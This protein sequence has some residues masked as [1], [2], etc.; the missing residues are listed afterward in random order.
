MAR[1]AERHPRDARHVGD[2]ER[3]EDAVEVEL[4]IW[5]DV[6][7]DRLAQAVADRVVLDD[8]ALAADRRP[9][10]V[11]PDDDR[12]GRPLRAEGLELLV[13]QVVVLEVDDHDERERTRWRDARPRRGA[14]GLEG[15]QRAR[16]VLRV[17]VVGRP[18]GVDRP[19]GELLGLL[20]LRHVRAHLRSAATGRRA[21]G[22]C[23]ARRDPASRPGGLRRRGVLPLPEPQDRIDD[24][25]LGHRLVVAGEQ[26]RVAAHRVGDESLVGLG[27]L[28]QERGAVR[29]V[30]G[31]G[32]EVHAGPRHLRQRRSVT[33][34]SGWIVSTS[35][36]ARHRARPR[37][38]PSARAAA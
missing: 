14:G 35:S 26:R 1:I 29:E 10:R 22:S 11:P 5:A 24:V 27:R 15:S 32:P 12:A 34:S 16:D 13:D 23:P 20:L 3:I 31:D 18:A 19:R 28:R 8:R 4:V 21:S 2:D 33:R 9:I 30:H 25:P 17:G 37:S 6:E 7:H 36:F 38:R